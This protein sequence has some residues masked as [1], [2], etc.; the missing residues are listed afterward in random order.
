VLLL[1]LAVA[2]C[3]ST[4]PEAPQRAAEVVLIHLNDLYEI[5]ATEGGRA[6]GL[7]RVATV[8]ERLRAEGRTVLVTLGG[9]YLSP[10]VLGTA[11]VDGAP[12][13]GR[14]M[15]DVLNATGVDW[16]TFGNHEFDLPEPA[17]RA[18]LAESR[19]R[20]VSSN[21][22]AAD[23]RPFPGVATSA[24]ATLEAGGRTLRIGLLG[25]TIDSNRTKWVA[26][27]EPIGAAREAVEAL[28]DRVDAVVALTHLSLSQDADLVAAV[29]GIDVALGGH[30]HDNWTMRRG[31]RFVPV[32]KADAN[33][34][35]VAIVT[36]RFAPD[37][38]RPTVS[39]ALLPID[40]SIPASPRVE[41]LVRS[42]TDAAFDA[43]RRA[44]FAPESVV[45]DVREP[46]DGRE[47]VVRNRPGR[48]TGLIVEGLARE[49][50][51]IDVALFNGG[52]VR[53]DDVVPAGPVTE[54]DVLRILP[55]GGRVA[56]ASMTGALLERVLATGAVNEGTGGYLHVA[57][58]RRE[59][60][61]WLV[62]DRPIDPAARYVVALPAFLLTGLEVNMS[63][64]NRSNP[65]L[66]D[67]A[68]GRDVRRV[69]IDALRTAYGPAR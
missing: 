61:Q 43:F 54:Y 32:V 37:G 62:G 56:T 69:L 55:F 30:E 47:A 15:V 31:P 59:G 23:G 14:Q 9:D 48:L 22:V 25:V 5:D 1:A 41:R 11:V 10:S 57:G 19:F 45:A 42:W 16:A 68:E 6:G 27:R 33:A 24:V 44:G 17:F 20:I 50:P 53:I 40:A 36:L 58:A 63:W 65:D 52:S 29:P 18:R 46:L 34:R 38:R 2:A 8:V 39:T 4:P 21:V 13:A 60:R 51:G 35:S 64:L 28:G 49:A 66:R 3:A 26:Y 67:V 7:A 12:L